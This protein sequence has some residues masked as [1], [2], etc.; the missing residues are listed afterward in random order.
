[1]RHLTESRQDLF[2]LALFLNSQPESQTM[3]GLRF[4][5]RFLGRGEFVVGV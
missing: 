2:D 1:M 3:F 4:F 5:L